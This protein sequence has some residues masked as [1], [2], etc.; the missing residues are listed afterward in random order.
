V[1]TPAP[2]IWF[3]V[4]GGDRRAAVEEIAHRLRDPFPEVS[5]IATSDFPPK[6]ADRSAVHYT[7]PPSDA[8]GDIQAFLKEWRPT[9]LVWL[10]AALRPK[11]LAEVSAARVPHYLVD[12]RSGELEP[13][14]LLLR[15]M[16]LKSTLRGFNRLLAVGEE[17]AELLKSLGAKPWSVEVV[18]PLVSGAIALPHDEAE[19]AF[20]AETLATRPL[21]YAS[22]LPMEELPLVLDAHTDALRR[23]HRFLL[24]IN[25]SELADA[26]AMAQSAQDEGFRVVRRSMTDE[27]GPEDQVVIA[28]LEEEHGLWYRLAPLSFMGGTF[29]MAPNRNPFEPAALGSAILHGPRIKMHGANFGRLRAAGA[30]RELNSASEFGGALAAL[31]TPDQS[32]RLAHAAWDVSSSGAEVVDRVIALLTRV[33]QDA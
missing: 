5:C 25:P 6:A 21:W 20:L 32:A 17:D 23:A 19:R 22:H 27:I 16:R 33:G 26:A 18:G 1:A 14:G 31:S 4:P 11:L 29:S 7:F 24:V 9:A 12:A 8:R 30:S 15:R 28:D 2:V 10:G 3:H 13:P